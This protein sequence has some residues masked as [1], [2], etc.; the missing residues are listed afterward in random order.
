M[1]SQLG[2]KVMSDSQ[3]GP[4]IPWAQIHVTRNFSAP[5]MANTM[6]RDDFYRIFDNIDFADNSK[7]PPEDSRYYDKTYNV[8]SFLNLLKRNFQ[9]NYSLLVVYLDRRNNC[10]I[11]R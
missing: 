1:N 3:S 8:K 10:E 4:K 7:T 11:Q 6:T 2:P 9:R 5:V